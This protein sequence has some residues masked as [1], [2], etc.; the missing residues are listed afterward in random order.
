MSAR[1]QPVKTKVPKPSIDLVDFAAHHPRLDRSMA[2]V[3]G[4]SAAYCVRAHQRAGTA[5]LTVRMRD[6]SDRRFPLRMPR[7]DA[8]VRASYAETDRSVEDGAYGIGLQLA[9]LLFDVRFFERTRKAVGNQCDFY[10]QPAQGAG[11]ENDIFQNMW[12]LEASGLFSQA[13]GV[14][15]QRV[16][17]KQV[18]A[19]LAAT[20]HTV[21]IVVVEFSRRVSIVDVR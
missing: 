5:H 7:V 14:Q 15:N 12:L 10:L 17:E 11:D 3:F 1:K 13:E 19:A 21:L 4:K 16:R 18:Q 20:L 2:D 9:A 6:K 8:N